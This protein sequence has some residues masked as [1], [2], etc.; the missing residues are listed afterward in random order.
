M[1]EFLLAMFLVSMHILGII[2]VWFL[3][4]ITIAYAVES[5]VKSALK[6]YSVEQRKNVSHE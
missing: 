4:F 6:D 2:V 5:G 1:K 3:A